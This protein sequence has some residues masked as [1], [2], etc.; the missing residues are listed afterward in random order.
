MI[1]PVSEEK[2]LKKIIFLSLIVFMLST[3]CALGGTSVFISPTPT[4]VPTLA[5]PSNTPTPAATL[6][7][8]ITATAT[9]IPPTST[10]TATPTPAYPP[11]GRGPD[12]FAADIDPLTGLEV[13]APAILD[14]RPIVIKVENLPREHRPQWGLSLADLVYEYYTEEGSTR[15]AAVFYGNDAD[16]VGPIRSGRFFD[17]NVVQMYKAIFVYGGAWDKVQQRFYNSDF[18]NR[19]IMELGNRSCPAVCRFDPTGQNLLVSDTA[20]MNNYLDKR[21]VDNTRQDENG[22][23]FKLETPS[24][25]DPASQVY[26]RYS[27]A[28]YN[29]WDYD[30]ASG[31]YLRFSD[32]QNDLNH[33]NEVYE[34]LTDRLTNKPIAADTL[35]V[36]CAPHQ[37]FIKNASGEVIDIIMDTRVASY[38]GCDGQTYKGGSGPAYV[39]RDGKMYKVTWQRAKRD[40]VLTLANPDGSL[41]PFKPGQTWFEVLGASSKV[42]PIGGGVW[43]FTHLM[44]P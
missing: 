11:E 22:M 27:G 29:R 36:M 3:A 17:T 21:K 31:R 33:N 26:V 19:L 12:N 20:A 1:N 15:F 35:V 41:F 4:L 30:A 44:V 16:R 10:P 5:L 24:G 38:V 18:Y 40:S 14:R 23:F 7:P 37:Y 9:P 2:P 8:T 39:A 43:R 32:K 25:G 13:K 42:D 28:I 34:Q 6:T